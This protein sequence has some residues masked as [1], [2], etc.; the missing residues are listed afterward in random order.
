M[1]DGGRW[2]AA[3]WRSNS[4]CC[5]LIFAMVASRRSS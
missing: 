1:N 4:A 3:F 2:R 5:R